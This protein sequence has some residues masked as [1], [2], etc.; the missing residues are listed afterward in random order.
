M[1]EQVDRLYYVIRLYLLVCLQQIRSPAVKC[2]LT[3]FYSDGA[4][5]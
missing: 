4:E 5:R 2:E 1:N 3:T